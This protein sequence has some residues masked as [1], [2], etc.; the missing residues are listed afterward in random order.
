MNGFSRMD[1]AEFCEANYYFLLDPDYDEECNPD[2]ESIN[3]YLRKTGR[4]LLFYLLPHL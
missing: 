3:D 2:R 4:Q 1:I